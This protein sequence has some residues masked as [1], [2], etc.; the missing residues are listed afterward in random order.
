MIQEFSVQ[1]F[2]SF[3]EKQT[4]SFVATSDKTRKEE[5]TFETKPRGTRL[6]RLAMIYG[7]NASGK[8]NLLQAIQTLWFMMFTPCDKEHQNVQIYQP[9]ELEKG[10]PTCF[11]IT[12]WANK[13]RFQYKLIYNK[14]SILHEKMMYGSNSDVLS[15]MYER[16]KGEPIQFGTTI[17][18]KAEQRKDLIRDTFDNHTLLSTLNKKNVDVPEIMRNLYDWIKNNVHE[19]DIYNNAMKIAEQAEENPVIKNMILELLNKADFN[20]VDFNTID[21]LPS[22]NVIEAITHNDELTESAKEKLLRPIKQVIFTHNTAK[23]K[24]QLNFKLESLGTRMYFRLARL[25]FDLKN[26]ECVLME[27]EL[28]N[29]LH[30]DLLLHYLQTY[31]QAS[32]CSQ[33]IFTTHNQLLLN[34]DWLIRRDMVWL[35]EKNHKSSSSTLYRASDMG[36]HKNVS[37]MNAYK[38]GKLGAKPFLGSTYLNS[39]NL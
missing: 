13:R 21:I 38:I 29:S 2:L 18:I 30:Y 12:F 27:D 7:A 37:L 39:E 36:I 34:E 20:I 14:Y 8:S 22:E 5:L 1:N 4:I 26:K 10:A 3:R 25:L 15:L 23:E 6:L 28:E 24:F 17:G 32:C 9:F 11:E 33:L 35:V 16:K 19:L 31:L